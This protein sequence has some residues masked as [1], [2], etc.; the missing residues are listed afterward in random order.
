MPRRR[1][2]KLPEG[3]LARLPESPEA[4]D[5]REGDQDHLCVEMKEYA[6]N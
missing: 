3:R 6:I 4:V 1:A 2:R 5:W